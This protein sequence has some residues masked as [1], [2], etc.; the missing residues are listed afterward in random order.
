MRFILHYKAVNSLSS[1]NKN[2]QKKLHL[3]HFTNSFYHWYS[4]HTL[5]YI[6][7][8]VGKIDV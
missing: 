3:V 4:F 8:G 6:I 5:W 2:A 1:V 7:F